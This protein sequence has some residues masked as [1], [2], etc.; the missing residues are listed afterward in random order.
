M[1]FATNSA[2]FPYLAVWR[3]WRRLIAQARKDANKIYAGPRQGGGKSNQKTKSFSSIEKR[4]KRDGAIAAL[5]VT[6]AN[7]GHGQKKDHRAVR[8]LQFARRE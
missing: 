7:G 5:V 8:Q 2:Y 3:Y 6:D 4:G 1:T